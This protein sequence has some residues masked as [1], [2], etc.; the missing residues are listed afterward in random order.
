MLFPKCR[1]T[2]WLTPKLVIIMF[3]QRVVCPNI[4]SVHYTRILKI[5]HAIDGR[6]CFADGIYVTGGKENFIKSQKLAHW[7][8]DNQELLI[9][10]LYI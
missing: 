9:K 1:T 7:S 6:Y 10:V 3:N 8:K 5:K 4:Q 2:Q